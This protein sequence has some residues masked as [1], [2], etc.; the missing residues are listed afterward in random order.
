MVI[1]GRWP[2]VIMKIFVRMDI[3]IM[4]GQPRDIAAE[5]DHYGHQLMT[6]M[7]MLMKIIS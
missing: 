2:V 6:E 4:I 5:E 1:I 3:I 7:K